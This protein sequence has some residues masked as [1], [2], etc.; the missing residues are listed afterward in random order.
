MRR[1]AIIGVIGTSIALSGCATNG[2][3]SHNQAVG[4]LGGCAAGA[5]AG[6][7]IGK[8]WV[9]AL[10]GCA[11]G[12]LGGYSIAS[13]LDEQE[14]RELVEARMRALE[15]G[16]RV[17]WGTHVAPSESAPAPAS[18][19]REANAGGPYAR[20]H[21]KYCETH[22]IYC[23]KQDEK[24][25]GVREASRTKTT[26]VAS[27]QQASTKSAPTMSGATNGST[28]VAAATGWVIPVRTYTNTS[29]QTCR[30]MKEEA[31]KKGET[32]SDSFTGCKAATGWVIQNA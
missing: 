16:E 24:E 26:K 2:E 15:S 28:E 5:A 12:A 11:A 14:K 4:I 17:D 29:G 25:G 7:A 22:Q 23:E 31:T 20:R 6:G 30:E 19:N 18:S 8:D 32:R 9:S 10:I 21:M 1:F 27:T 13:M 3:I